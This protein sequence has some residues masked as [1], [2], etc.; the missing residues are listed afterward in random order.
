MKG[1]NKNNKRKK[2]G[3]TIMLIM[4]FMLTIVL[5][6]TLTLAWFYDTDWASQSVTMAGA[7]G[8][9]MREE[10]GKATSGKGQLHFKLYNTSLA[11]PGQAIEM[12]ASVFNNGGSSV[13][14]HFTQNPTTG[15]PANPGAG[16]TTEEIK[17]AVSEQDAL[18]AASGAGSPC[19]VRAYFEVFT[20]ITE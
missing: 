17:Q 15:Y 5:T 8:I 2:I 16:A 1:K 19:Y 13:V 9:E 6:A 20:N 14:N 18:I 3:V 4:S 11:Y 7:V 12:E 10:S